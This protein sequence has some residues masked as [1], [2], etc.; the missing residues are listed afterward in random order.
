MDKWNKYFTYFNSARMG[1]ILLRFFFSKQFR[2][3]QQSL[4][5]FTCDQKFPTK[6]LVTVEMIESQLKPFTLDL[7]RIEL[8]YLIR[9][10]RL[11]FEMEYFNAVKLLQDLGK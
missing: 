8:H 3:T 7:S 9:T 1:L 5:C 6:S 4:K 2:H 10:Q 11:S